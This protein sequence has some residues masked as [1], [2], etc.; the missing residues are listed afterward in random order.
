MPRKPI[1]LSD[2]SIEID[3]TALENVSAG[4]NK[5][6]ST[7]RNHDCTNN[8]KIISWEQVR[9]NA[10]S[11]MID[12]TGGRKSSEVSSC[13]RMQGNTLSSIIGD[14]DKKNKSPEV[15][16]CEQVESNTPSYMIDDTE[17]RVSSEDLDNVCDE[18]TNLESKG[19]GNSV[20]SN[21]TSNRDN[22]YHGI[23]LKGSSSVIIS[24]DKS[25]RRYNKITLRS[26]RKEKGI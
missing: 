10:P 20:V 9:V 6:S 7:Y 3:Q 16:S 25:I 12:D 13:E 1:T 5:D 15:S 17:K 19:T 22:L 2:V 14:T 21:D 23:D 4:H 11:S 26:K 24:D 18:M 8:K